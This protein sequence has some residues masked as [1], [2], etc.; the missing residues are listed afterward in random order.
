VTTSTDATIDERTLPE[1]LLQYRV[2]RFYTREAALLD[3][4]EYEQWVAL[5]SDDTHYFMPLRRTLPRRERQREFTSPG[6]MAFFDDNKALLTARVMKLAT[7]TAWAEDPPSRTRH[8]ITNVRIVEVDGPEVSVDSNFLL[9]RSRLRAEEDHW[10]G[11]RRDL[12]RRNGE[13]FEIARRHVFLDQTVL[14]SQNLS[15]FF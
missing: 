13:G 7:G 15:N 6:E 3:Q 1:M 12:L 5:F 2:E 11:F 8:L 14:L 10:F 4:H 9:Y